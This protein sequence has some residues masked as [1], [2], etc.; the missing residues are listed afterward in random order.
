MNKQAN[1]QPEKLTGKTIEL[2]KKL[3]Q[4]KSIYDNPAQ[5][6]RVL[7]IALAELSRF[8]VQ[9][10]EQNGVKSALISNRP[11]CLNFK[12]LLN[13]HVDVVTGLADQFV[14]L[15]KSG[16]LYGRGAQDMKAATAAMIEVFKS[17]ADKVD[18]PLGL[19]IVTDEEVGGHN[20][21]EYQIAQGIT[22][23]FVIVGEPSDLRI[24]NRAKGV[25][26]AEL[27][28]YGKSAHGAY[29]WQGESAILKM[30]KFLVNLDD[31][32]GSQGETEW[33]TTCDVPIVST[34]NKEFN[35]VAADCTVQLDIRYIPEEGA[36]KVIMNL[37]EKLSENFVLEVL[38]IAPA[39]F[40][41][42][43]NEDI[44]RLTAILKAQGIEIDAK[45]SGK[46]GATDGKYYTKQGIPVVIWGLEGGG[47]HQDEEWVAIS[48]IEKYCRVLTEFLLQG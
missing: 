25:V 42:A 16:R 46:N 4:V 14:P 11:G 15:V 19:Q 37:K 35:K 9:I 32:V 3:I 39:Q 8:P 26:K 7:E 23:D 12:Y 48:S 43:D 44:A 28:A 45:L 20:G 6:D 24:I 41:K 38:S 5:L 13:G 30:A 2:A 18:Y 40:T 21:T 10:F 22:A 36:E 31:F 29:P 17:V 47:L 1:K 33:V 34:T 27:T